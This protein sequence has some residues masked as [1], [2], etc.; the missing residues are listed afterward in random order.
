MCDTDDNYTPLNLHDPLPQP[1]ENIRVTQERITSR[2]A[3]PYMEDTSMT[4]KH[5]MSIQQLG[6]HE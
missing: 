6:M 3:K 2:I 1:N 4:L 5:Q